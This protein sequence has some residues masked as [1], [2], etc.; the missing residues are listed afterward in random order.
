MQIFV[1]AGTVAAALLLVLITD[2][3]IAGP[4][5]PSPGSLVVLPIAWMAL[6][7]A[8]A[9]VQVRSAYALPIVAPPG[10]HAPTNLVY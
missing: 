4:Q 3:S 7:A 10:S 8:G 1:V 6:F 2:P 9:L 5:A